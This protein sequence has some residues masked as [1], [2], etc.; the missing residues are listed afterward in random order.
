MNI[1]IKLISLP[2]LL[3]LFFTLL[4]SNTGVWFFFGNQLTLLLATQF[5]IF[6]TILL[7]NYTKKIYLLE[8]FLYP[9]GLIYSILFFIFPIKNLNLG[10]GLLL[11]ENLLLETKVFG[12]QFTLDE[13]L[14]S[15]IH[16][17]LYSLLGGDP[18]F[19][20]YLLSSIAGTLFILLLIKFLKR[21]NMG[22]LEFLL[23]L[24]SG[25][26]FLFHG[27]VENYTLTTLLITI[28]IFTTYANIQNDNKNL[29]LLVPSALLAIIAVSF[30][31]VAGY[32][33]FSLIYLA[34]N[35]SD[36]DK[37]IK[38]SVISS[39]IAISILITF[40]SYF[41][42]FA[43][44]PADRTST[45][46][47]HPPFYSLKGMI[48]L[49]HFYE[50]IGVLIFNAMPA[51]GVI[52]F[53]WVNNEKIFKEFFIKK[54]N[55]FLI[56]VFGG[57]VLHALIHTPQLGF[58]ADWDLMGFYWLPLTMIAALLLG[59]VEIIY[60]NVLFPFIIFLL[61]IHLI[62]MIE[63]NKPDKTKEMKLISITKLINQYSEI[64]PNISH[65]PAN[66]KKFYIKTDFFLYRT[67][68]ILKEAGLSEMLKEKNQFKKELDKY[69]YN[70]QSTNKIWLTNYLKR[71]TA[72]HIKYLNLEKQL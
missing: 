42:F 39:I 40:L 67:G 1:N 28:Y 17:K 36:R 33:I 44:P 3:V 63:L 55:Q 12:F 70:N 60:K 52:L 22:L 34:W 2:V 37:F 58:P 4:V 29:S 64:I 54:E 62:N 19:T 14:E 21:N 31:L 35:F 32:L 53:I 8:K 59:K 18:R 69:F 25:G 10:D 15:L 26:M 5:F 50:I 7:M 41:L 71:L 57:F 65:L 45:I 27:Y 66:Q 6:F 48:S 43:D 9:T 24:S 56:S 51:F 30:H 13:I 49:N 16:S 61:I 38:N 11:L 46:I 72:F 20:Y 68:E 23:F 47:F